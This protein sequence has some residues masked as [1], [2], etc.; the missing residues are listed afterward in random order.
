MFDGI[1]GC[2]SE[3]LNTLTVGQPLVGDRHSRVLSIV[4]S[5]LNT[6]TV[7][8]PLVGQC[9]LTNVSQV[10]VESQYP[11]SRAA[12]CR[13]VAGCMRYFRANV[14]IPSQSGS[15]LSGFEE[16]LTCVPC[17]SSQYP[18]SRAASCRAHSDVATA[19]PGRSQY[20]HSRAASCRTLTV[21]SSLQRHRL[22]SIPSQSGSLLSGVEADR[23]KHAHPVSIPSQSG[24]LLSG[25]HGTLVEHGAARSQYPHSRAASCRATCPTAADAGARVSIPS[26]S[27]SLL[28]VMSQRNGQN[29][30]DH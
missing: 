4:V 19:E 24:S 22:V 21:T 3:R 15:L 26:Q 6:L 17:D 23:L 14:S 1:R 5:S 9:T 7:G 12:S 28:S 13:A 11:H 2:R 25:L 10:T 29:C 27:G 18:H 20:P 8:Q 30:P 16:A